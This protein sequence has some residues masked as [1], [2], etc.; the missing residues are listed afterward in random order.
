MNSKEQ[1]KREL[2]SAIKEFGLT[3]TE[4]GLAISG[5]K[6]FMDIMDDDTKS[7]TTNTVDKAMRYVLELRG[8]GVFKFDD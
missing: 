8:Q 7:I 5:S 3:R 1:I 4:V 6:S 2:H